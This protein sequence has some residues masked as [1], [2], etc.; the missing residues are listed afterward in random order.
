MNTI[1]MI[2]LCAQ[3]DSFFFIW[4]VEILINNLRDL[5]VEPENIHILIGYDS[6]INSEWSLFVE[7]NKELACFFFYQD[8]RL[9][10]EY[11]SSLRPNI[12]GQHFESYPYLEKATIFYHDADIIFK[13][14]PD[15]DSLGVD[16]IWYVSDTKSYLG[17]DYIKN[18]G[19]EELIDD[20]CSI[21]GVSKCLV[22]ENDNNCGGA[23]YLI[24]NVSKDFWTKI[25]KD[26]EN[27][28]V[29]L[30]DF[31]A[32]QASDKYAIDR[33]RWSECASGFIQAWCADMWCVLWN[34]WSFGFKTKI[35]KELDFCFP[36]MSI[37]K[38][39]E[40]KILHYTGAVTPK[41]FFKEKY[42]YFAPYYSNFDHIERSSCSYPLIE[43]ITELKEKKDLKRVD[44]NTV[45]ILIVVKLRSEDELKNFYTTIEFLNKYFKTNIMVGEY[46]KNSQIDINKIGDKCR[47]Y[48]FKETKGG[49]NDQ[50]VTDL[51]I[52][53]V[54]TENFII[55]DNGLIIDPEQ[56]ALALNMI[57][58]E[59]Y[60]LVCPH[61][62]FIY[63]VDETFS[64]IFRT[65]LDFN[66]LE[67]NINCF[68]VESK[69][70]S[71]IIL[72]ANTKKYLAASS[73]N[74]FISEKKTLNRDALRHLQTLGH[75]IYLSNE[76]SDVLLL[77][78]NQS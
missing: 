62:E 71:R 51:L 17:I 42:R 29:Y 10:K 39:D 8:L 46:G 49:V 64:T 19:S 3:S 65:T 4:Q 7:E 12:I 28:Y 53:N 25:E 57:N 67:H 30:R 56:I 76:T 22:Y 31:N 24:K 23:Q 27:L 32:K 74:E 40:M 21:I 55:Y 78:T 16:E 45:S 20:M 33:S 68:N 47:Y 37:D 35:H 26:S 1:H 41:T 54:S 60:I 5:N 52:S 11:L 72:V 58:T 66:I 6:V 43:K 2:Y 36:T 50:I 75:K 38:W 44:L 18:Y 15:F 69:G 63:K 34:A 13:E 59:D 73:G 61:T 77:N 14:L 9:S 48:F 70:C